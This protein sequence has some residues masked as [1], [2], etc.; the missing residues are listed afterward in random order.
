MLLPGRMKL[1][2]VFRVGV[3]VNGDDANRR[4]GR[5]RDDDWLGQ[6][7]AGGGRSHA[8]AADVR[9]RGDAP[10]IKTNRDTHSSVTHTEAILVSRTDKCCLTMTIYD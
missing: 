3:T 2:L 5:V 10:A 6:H 8:A 1:A 4:A 7:G 9:R